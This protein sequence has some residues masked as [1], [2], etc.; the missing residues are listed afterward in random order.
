V[1][2]PAQDIR[3][4]AILFEEEG[5]WCA[6]CLEYDIAVQA[7]TLTDVQIELY[8]ALFSQVVAS[9]ELGREPFAGLGAA[10]PRY[11]D[12][13]ENAKTTVKR[14]EPALRLP[15]EAAHVSVSPRLKLAEQRAVA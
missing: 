4:S 12:M 15:P 2:A 13:F 14:E 7:K 1:A 5:Q 8:R 11:W 10:P 6:Q 3:I 9:I